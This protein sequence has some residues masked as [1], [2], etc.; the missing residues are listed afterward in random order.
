MHG[1]K[2]GDSCGQQKRNLTLFSKSDGCNILRQ[3]HNLHWIYQ[4]FGF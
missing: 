2:G 4:L 1:I 3:G